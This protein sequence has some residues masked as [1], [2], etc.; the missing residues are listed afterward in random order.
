MKVSNC[1]Y[2]NSTLLE[3]IVGWPS[4]LLQT[5]SVYNQFSNLHN[6][7]V[8]VYKYLYSEVM[9]LGINVLYYLDKLI[10]TIF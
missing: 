2:I 5:M 6:I 8:H 1:S 4:I 7:H 10:F 9:L 3:G